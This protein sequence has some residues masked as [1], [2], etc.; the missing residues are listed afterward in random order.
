MTAVKSGSV[1][2]GDAEAFGLLAAIG[3]TCR[4]AVVALGE[5]EWVVYMPGPWKFPDLAVWEGWPVRYDRLGDV[6]PACRNAR[7]S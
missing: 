2:R 3:M 7:I 4:D 1:V 6:V 5:G